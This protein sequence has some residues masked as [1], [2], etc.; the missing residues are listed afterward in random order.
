MTTKQTPL[1]I[2]GIHETIYAGFWLR[3]GA[4]LLDLIVMSPLIILDILINGYSRNACYFTF[5]F[6][7]L[8]S[9]GYNVYF[10]KKFGGTPGKLVT[11]LKIIRIDGKDIGWKEAFLRYSVDLAFIIFIGVISIKSNSLADGET[12]KSL[13][14]LK[15]QE[16]L[17]S[18]SPILF[19]IH[20]WINNIWIYGELIVL[21]TN[22]RKRALHDFIANTVIVKAMYLDKIRMAMSENEEVQIKNER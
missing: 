19:K 17:M 12:L 10:V 5:V 6:M 2:D 16:Y 8:I 1:Q 21:L 20:S 18:F 13:A 11:G 15:R 14:W 9:I 4:L 7:L 22:K 3:F